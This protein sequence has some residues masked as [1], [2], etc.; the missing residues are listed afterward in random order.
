MRLYRIGHALAHRLW[1]IPA[2]GVLAGILLSLITV[3]ID[4]RN[5]NGLGG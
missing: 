4:R 3:M 5:E 2:L 1:I